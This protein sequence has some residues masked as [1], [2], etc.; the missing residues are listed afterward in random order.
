[1]GDCKAL[2]AGTSHNLGS[3]FAKAG[4]CDFYL[5]LHYTLCHWQSQLQLPGH[6]RAGR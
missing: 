5:Q 3:N 4:A 2:Q 1:M 6:R